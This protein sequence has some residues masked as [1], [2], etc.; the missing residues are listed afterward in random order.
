MEVIPNK[1]KNGDL[2]I[3]VLDKSA[4]YPTSGGQ[5]NDVGTL[6][7]KGVQ[8]EVIDA[9]KIGKAVLHFLDKNVTRDII[10]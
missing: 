2:N 4:Y 6:T 3:V 1:L 5:Q 10:G 8:Y 9:Q 7:I